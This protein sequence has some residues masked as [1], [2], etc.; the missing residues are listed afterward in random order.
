MDP[1]GAGHTQG[2]MQVSAGG[3]PAKI[4]A[5]R[6]GAVSRVDLRMRRPSVIQA[7][8]FSGRPLIS[9][10]SNPMPFAYWIVLACGLVSLAYG[11]VA[12]KV[13]MA[14]PTGNDRMREIAAAVQE[15]AQAY[16]KRQYMTIAMVGAVVCVLLSVLL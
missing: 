4:F 10:L 1:L 3:R 16:L 11:A 13:V 2:P 8:H 5:Q 9:T 14:A 6:C 15:G 7:R 12:Y